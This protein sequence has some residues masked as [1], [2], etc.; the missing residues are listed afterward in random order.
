MESNLCKFTQRAKGE[1]A[2]RIRVYYSLDLGENSSKEAHF[3]DKETGSQR[4]NVHDHKLII[5]GARKQTQQV[6]L[7]PTFP[8]FPL[9]E[10]NIFVVHSQQKYI[11]YLGLL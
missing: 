5:G 4:L 10:V 2:Q 6:C 7:S 1:F 9:W 3:T 8:L 11:S